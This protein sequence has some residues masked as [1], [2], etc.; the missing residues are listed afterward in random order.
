M[1]VLQRIYDSLPK[2]SYLQQIC[3]S[4]LELN[5]VFCSEFLFRCLSRVVCNELAF[6]VEMGALQR[7]CDSLLKLRVV[8][9][10]V[11]FIAAKHIG[12]SEVAFGARIVAPTEKQFSLLNYAACS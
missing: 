3:D 10:E 8:C 6:V 7:I 9:N 2:L 12:C 1:S 4:L 11:A 5:C